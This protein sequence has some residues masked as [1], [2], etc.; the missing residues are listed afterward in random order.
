MVV[1]DIT[2]PYYSE[3]IRGAEKRAQ[4]AGSGILIV[5]TEEDS[6]K[7][8]ESVERLIGRVDGF[9]LTSSRLT[10][11][12]I[13]TLADRTQVVLLNRHVE[14]IS[15]ALVDQD[16]GSQ[17]II[18]HLQR[19]GHVEL[20]FASGPANSWV[21]HQRWESL[22]EHSS[23]AG[24]RIVQLGPYRPSLEDG[25]LAARDVLRTGA[26]AV[27]AHN[28]L[29]ALGI[30]GYLQSEGIRVPEDLSVVGFDDMI[31]AR[32]CTPALTTLGGQYERAAHHGVEM[33]VEGRRAQHV[34]LPSRLQI[35]DSTGAV[36]QTASA[37][38]R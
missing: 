34:V 24:L 8:R 7:E 22:S 14:G 35:R 13:R 38:T 1:P 36:P 3:A 2:N 12:E 26:T 19:L 33:L 18:E 30:L 6:D 20:A 15:S 21:R 29:L 11:D 16:V 23:R 25:A 37:L 32:I 28:D 5:N 9:V 27:I 10:I 4:A 17:S 31:A